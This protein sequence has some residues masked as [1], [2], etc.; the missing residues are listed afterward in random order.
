MDDIEAATAVEADVLAP[1]TFIAGDKTLR[2]GTGTAGVIAHDHQRIHFTAT[3]RTEM[4]EINYL[5]SDLA[6]PGGDVTFLG[7]TPTFEQATIF[8]GCFGGA[9][10]TSGTDAMKLRFFLD[11]VQQ[12][13]SGYLLRFSL[14]PVQ[15]QAYKAVAAGDRVVRLDAHNYHATNSYRCYNMGVIFGAGCK[16]T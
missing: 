13:E 16:V 3:N 10:A 15:S 11:G 9:Y 8:E 14:E 7:T 5:Q 12:S 2:T 4:Q 1:E 6:P